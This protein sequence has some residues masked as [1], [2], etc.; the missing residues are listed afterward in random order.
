[1]TYEPID[2]WP[3]WRGVKVGPTSHDTPES[4]DSDSPDPVTARRPSSSDDVPGPV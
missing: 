3:G 4:E 1:M 2:D